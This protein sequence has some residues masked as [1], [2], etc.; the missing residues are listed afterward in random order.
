MSRLIIEEVPPLDVQ[1]GSSQGRGGNLVAVGIFSAAIFFGC[2]FGIF[3]RPVGHLSAFWLAN[4][5]MLGMMIRDHR[6]VTPLGMVAAGLAFVCADLVTGGHLAPTLLLTAANVVGVMAGYVFFSRLNV[7]DQRLIHPHSVLYL[8]LGAAVAAGA[9]G[10]V[11]A[12]INPFLYGGTMAEGWVLWA[13]TEFVNYIAILPVILTMPASRVEL[14]EIL[15]EYSRPAMS[16]PAIALALSCMASV[17]VGGPGAIGFP[18][19]ALLWC[20]LVYRPFA[21]AILTLLFSICTLLGISMGYISIFLNN[22]DWATLMSLR[23]GVSMVALAPITVA[24]VI[25]ARNELMQ[26]LRQMAAHDQLTNLLNRGAFKARAEALLAGLARKKHPA[27]VLMLDIDHFKRINDTYGHAAGDNVLKAVTRL[28]KSNLR[29]DDLVGRLG[30]EEFAVL[31]TGQSC[32]HARD[33]AERI[34]RSFEQ[35]VIDLGDG[36]NVT[37]TV[38]GGLF[39]VEGAI[40]DFDGMML[41]ADRLLYSAK[42]Q[43]RNRIVRG[44]EDLDA[45]QY[46]AVG[47]ARQAT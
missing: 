6:L 11:G 4:A 18:V 3:T 5:L 37:A 8:V 38:S 29:P 33:I 39:T 1:K 10:I 32:L 44:G 25:A 30:G 15:A 12:L 24:S 16:V 41:S 22:A 36:R 27:A 34:R 26:Y 17:L 47:S 2:L 7:F 13:V 42:R 23:I 21:T 19:P 45:T 31:L 28:L 46:V 40:V 43:G 14:K 20:A 9:A 35:T